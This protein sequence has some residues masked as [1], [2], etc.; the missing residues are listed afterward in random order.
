MNKLEYQVDLLNAIN[1]KLRRDE[2]MLRL[3]CETSNSAFLYY[4]YE[5][6]KVQ[7]IANWDHFFD[8][9]IQDIRDLTKLYDCVE[10]KY[11][12]SLR[13][14]LFIEKQGIKSQSIEIRLK[15]NRIC[16]EV[17]VNI[18]YDDNS[19][20]TDK[21]IRF[22]DVT[23][24]NAQNDEL[25]Y[26]AYYD[27]LTG[28]YNRNYFVR[29]LG[30]FV[31]RAGEENETVAVMFLDVD[32][33]RKINDGMGIIVGDELVQL[34]GQYLIDLMGDNVVISHFNSDIYCIGI[35]GPYGA[36]SVETIHQGAA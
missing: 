27:I 2:K 33:F 29:L 3:I 12:I 23:K 24:F 4:N 22:K 19:R 1:K 6:E 36:R 17:E 26:M 20:P 18:V 13:E 10:E 11:M 32:D 30:E 15:E 21:I 5:E 14:V 28:L 25:T 8:F 7:T 34:F 9:T 31:R 16:I 35:Y